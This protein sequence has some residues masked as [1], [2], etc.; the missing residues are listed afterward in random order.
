MYVPI[1]NDFPFV[2]LGV[3]HAKPQ[4]SSP[5][6]PKKVADSPIEEEPIENEKSE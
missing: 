2:S 4:P 6:A 1:L 3:C 5:A